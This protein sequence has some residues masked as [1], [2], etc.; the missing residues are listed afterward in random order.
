MENFRPSVGPLDN[1]TTFHDRIA[2]ENWAQFK[3]KGNSC[4]LLEFR[5]NLRIRS[6]E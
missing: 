1:N 6:R 2:D 4:G 3:V 5:R